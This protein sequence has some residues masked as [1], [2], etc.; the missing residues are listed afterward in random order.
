MQGQTG[1][2]QEEDIDFKPDPIE[3]EE[4]ERNA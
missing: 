2:V 4:N 1:D 3:W